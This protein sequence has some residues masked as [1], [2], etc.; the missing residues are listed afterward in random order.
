MI[1]QA[2]DFDT[3]DDHQNIHNEYTDKSMISYIR[4][5]IDHPGEDDNLPPGKNRFA[6][7]DNEITKSILIMLDILKRNFGIE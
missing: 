1:E 3:N 6:P 7:T 5:Y 4:N 2:P